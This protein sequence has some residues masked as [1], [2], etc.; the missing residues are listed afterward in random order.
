[1]DI[2]IKKIELIEWLTKIEDEG[3]INKIADLKKESET[4]WWDSLTN[5]QQEDI[6]AGLDDIEAGKK[7][8]FSNSISKYN[9]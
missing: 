9:K 3:L 6:Q 8:I 7:Q 4:D 1:M 2:S 5:E